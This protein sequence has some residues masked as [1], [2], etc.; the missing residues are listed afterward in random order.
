[1]SHNP[2]VGAQ[3]PANKRLIVGVWGLPKTRKTTIGL[4]GP[5][6]IR[7]INFD[8]GLEE[9]LYQF[10]NKNIEH[11]GGELHIPGTFDVE[12]FTKLLAKAEDRYRW[13]LE[14]TKGGTVIVDTTTEFWQLVQDVEL[15]PVRRRRQARAI[16]ANKDPDD[17]VL[18]PFDYGN[19]NRRM[20]GFLKMPHKFPGV[21]VVWTFR[22]KPVYD[23]KGQ[24]IPGLYDPQ[25]H[26]EVPSWAQVVVHTFAQP[27]L[28]KTK[29]PT[30]KQ[31]FYGK[32]T[33]NRYVN[34]SVGMDIQDL[35][36]PTLREVCFDG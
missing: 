20:R 27:E 36:Y 25:W 6:P 14:N 12:V 34:E 31:L 30:G 26:N 24:V 15:E 7:V 13:A 33:H 10:P 1:M 19:A 11:T 29:K 28:D 2:F 23:S 3:T 32:I 22:S 18:Y 8:F 4:T 21:N 5:E 16:A 9:L 17:I 35:D